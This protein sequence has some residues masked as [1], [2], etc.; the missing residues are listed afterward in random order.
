M[1]KISKMMSFVANFVSLVANAYESISGCARLKPSTTTRRA[2]PMR[3]YE[4]M[5]KNALDR[6][7]G[8]IRAGA[9]KNAGIPSAKGTFEA[10]V[11]SCLLE[12]TRFV[13]EE[14]NNLSRN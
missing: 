13:E 6:V 12:E 11:P 4:R 9:I 8:S 10:K 2:L 5:K 1:V 7:L 3:L 14:A